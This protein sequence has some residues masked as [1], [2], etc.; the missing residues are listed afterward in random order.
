M[1]DGLIFHLSQASKPFLDS[2]PKDFTEFPILK[3]CGCIIT[4]S[5]Q[6]REALQ[7]AFQLAHKAGVEARIITNNEIKDLVPIIRGDPDAVESGIYDPDAARIDVDALLQGYIKGARERGC[8]LLLRAMVEKI[9]CSEPGGV[10]HIGDESYRA[11]I[12]INASGAWADEIASLAGVQPLGIEPRRR[13]M[14]TFD[15]PTGMDITDWPMVGDISSSFYFLPESGQLMGSCAD[16]SLAPPCD[17]QPEEIDIATAV[18]NIEQHT[19][20][21]IKKIN[22]SWAGLRSF[23]PD[24]NPAVGFDPTA[25]NFFWFAGLGGFGIQ[26]APALAKLGAAIALEQNAEQLAGE[27]EIALNTIQPSRFR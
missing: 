9:D 11:P 12:L 22:H 19:T 23:T 10:I 16:E 21:A 20:I 7:S 8:K 13:T 17:A 5:Q 4:A 26:T 3:P 27:M 18:Y 14:I 6:H 25:P 24:R 1:H 15:A 2:P